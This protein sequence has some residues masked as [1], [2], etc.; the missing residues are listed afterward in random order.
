MIFI[1]KYDVNVGDLV[2][3]HKN[4]R[5]N[6][7]VLEIRQLGDGMFYKLFS[8]D[9]LRIEGHYE[10]VPVFYEIDKKSL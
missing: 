2:W 10:T 8:I 6:H 1:R 9:R 5:E 7:I 3:L 4:N